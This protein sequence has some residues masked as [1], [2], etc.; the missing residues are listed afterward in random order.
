MLHFIIYII[1]KNKI[2]DMKKRIFKNKKEYHE[3]LKKWTM[4]LLKQDKTLNQAH[5][6]I[7]AVGYKVCY[8]TLSKLSK[9]D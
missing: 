4:K 9:E 6:T 7:T 1:K 2:Y 8:N 5:T 3:F